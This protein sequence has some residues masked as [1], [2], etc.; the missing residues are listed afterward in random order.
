MMQVGLL[1]PV[2][3]GYERQIKHA[4]SLGF[5][6]GQISIWDMR[7]YTEDVA[8]RLKSLCREN[9]FVITGVW[10]GWSGPV[11]WSYPACYETLGLV[12]QWLRSRRLTE[13]RKGAGF[14]RTLGVDTVITHTGFIPDNPFDPDHRGVIKALKWLCGEIERDGQTFL[15]ETGEELPVTLIRMIDEIGAKNIGVNLDP[16]NLLMGGR[17]NPVDAVD[18]LL[19][20]IKGFHAKDAVRPTTDKPKGVERAIGKGQVDFKTVIKLIAGAG[21]SGDLTIE[22]ETAEGAER[23]RDIIEGKAYLEKL[24]AASGANGITGGAPA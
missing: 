4:V 8:L 15:F 9:N 22:R 16:A 19:P 3:R 17:A 13:L 2:D 18:L 24:V 12:P 7:L 23:D 6:S 10:C 11:D 20:W 1:I 21:Y 5:K 14:A